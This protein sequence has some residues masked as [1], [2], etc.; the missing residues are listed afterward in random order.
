MN[1]KTEFQKASTVTECSFISLCERNHQQ[2][3]ITGLFQGLLPSPVL[4]PYPHPE[5]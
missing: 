2:F 3:G 4:T 1:F 5:E